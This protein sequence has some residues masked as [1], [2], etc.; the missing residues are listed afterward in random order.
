MVTPDDQEILDDE[1][2]DEFASYFSSDKPPKVYLTTSAGRVKKEKSETMGFIK[3]MLI[4]IPNSTYEERKKRTL[5]DIIDTCKA[6]DYTDVMVINEDHGRPNGI[7]VSH[8]PDGPTCL[9]KLTNITLMKAVYNHASPTDHRPEVIQNNFNTRLGHTVARMLASLLPQN[10]Q[11]EGR[12]VITFH[13]QRDFIFFRQHRYI[14]DNA[15]KARLQEIGPRFTLKLKY[16]QHGTFDS[17]KGEYEW[18]QKP[19][20]ATSRR[21]FFL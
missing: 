4:T 18:I 5:K 15:K 17:K 2:I 6:Q 3:D 20:M 16:L 19:E 11:F 9:F 7:L 10:P 13:N 12:R 14:F 1:A 8:L 21:R